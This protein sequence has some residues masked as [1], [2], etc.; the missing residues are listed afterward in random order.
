MIGGTLR[1]GLRGRLRERL[2][3]E[4]SDLFEHEVGGH[5]LRFVGDEQRALDGVLEL[6]HVARPR[7]PEDVPP[8][9]RRERAGRHLGML[10]QIRFPE[11]LGQQERI[12]IALTQR[13]EPDGELK[14]PVIQILPKPSF[15]NHLRHVL[16]RRREHAY[17]H[18]D[19]LVATDAL[20]LLILEYA[21][22]LGLQ[23]EV[24]LADLVEEDRA[25]V[26]LLELADLAG[27]RAG[28]RA[29]LVSEE[30]ALHQLTRDGGA[31]DHHER[32]PTTLRVVVD[33]LGDEFLPGA[34]LALNGH[35]EVAAQG[36]F[37]EP[38]DP[39]HGGALPDDATQPPH[40]GQTLPERRE[41]ARQ[42]EA[43]G[44]V[45]HDGLQLDRVVVPFRDV[46]VRAEL[47]R[48]EGHADGRLRRDHHHRQ[49]RT[50]LRDLPERL[51]AALPRHHHVAQHEVRPLLE[52][53]DDFLARGEKPD[54]HV[55]M[56]LQVVPDQ[57][58][59]VRVVIDDEDVQTHGRVP[60][61]S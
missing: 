50:A 13:G 25:A 61:F 31:V 23:A 6:A 35:G 18:L 29:F 59:V 49:P 19:R 3:R 16:V 4:R 37:H 12:L 55:R 60:L 2:R 15:A 24:E 58:S 52:V 38:E 46:V 21:Q 53:G 28:E 44:H 43:L 17:V 34:A 36:L 42:A 10:L 26:G 20:Y 1:D 48:F 11:V 8:G 40:G 30:L 22:E 33:G 14:E 51:E 5:D 27:V 45:R 56:P 47:H 54:V 41:L 7:I 39:R 32:V 57:L 9:G